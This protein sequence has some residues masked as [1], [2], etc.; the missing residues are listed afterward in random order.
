MS[1]VEINV[2]VPVISWLEEPVKKS[3]NSVFGGINAAVEAMD[4]FK[5]Y[6]GTHFSMLNEAVGKVK[7]LGMSSPLMLM[8]LYYTTYVSSDIRRRLYESEWH[9]LH[10]ERARSTG[11]SRFRSIDGAAYVEKSK[12]LVVLGGPGAGKTT[13]L[14]FLALAYSNKEVFSKTKLKVEKL[15][16][17]LPLPDFSK[18]DDDVLTFLS[19]ALVMREGDFAR[20]FFERSMRKGLAVVLMD[21]LDEV[22][23]S[24]RTTVIER[25]KAFC[26]LYPDVKVVVSCRTADYKEILEN[27]DEV[28]LVRLSK[29]A[30]QSIVRSWFKG[31]KDLAD[32]LISVINSDSG[33]SNLTE[34]PLLLSLLCIQFKHDLILPRRKVEV[35][36]RCVE[37]LLRDWDTTRGFRRESSYESLSDLHKERLFE[38]LAGRGTDTGLTYIFSDESVR[39]I[40][41]DYISRLG[42]SAEE[43]PGIISE[44]ERHHGIVERH[45]IESL[46]FSH[47]SIQDYFVARDAI[48]CRKEQEIVKS[49]MDDESWSGVIE[50][51]CGLHPDPTQIFDLMVK[52]ASLKD[53]KNYPA[54]ERRAKLLYL[55]YRCMSVGPIL[56]PAKAVEINS[57]I[58]NSLQSFVRLMAGSGV[59]P[60]C[61]YGEGGVRH[62]YFYRGQQRPSLHAALLP[63]RKLSNEMLIRPVPGFAKL[64]RESCDELLAGQTLGEVE[65]SLL[66]NMIVPMSKVDPDGVM[67]VLSKARGRI[68]G[69]RLFEAIIDETLTTIAKNEAT[70]SG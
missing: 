2:E 22:P 63:Y 52:K 18:T 41:A 61:S 7:V 6:R 69:S 42:I 3:V 40:T 66:L 43:A 29:T 50:F 5:K 21:S 30:V 48:S 59:Y 20:D 28:E 70:A 23:E 39:S 27:F 49:R 17:F 65:L 10:E 45:S 68:E 60:M 15:P 58:L 67:D 46:C 31:R 32:K 34:T 56:L 53:L 16:V 26:N 37:T 47:A 9:T 36:K 35:Y 1:A 54:I 55:I 13:F 38:H 64:A 19:A 8:D 14:K 62:P 24:R 4:F 12:R 25:I 11:L 57:H 51:I 33:I 44:V